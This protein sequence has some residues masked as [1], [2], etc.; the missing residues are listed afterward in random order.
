MDKIKEFLRKLGFLLFKS[1]YS[2]RILIMG[3]I[4]SFGGIAYTSW[5]NYSETA[6]VAASDSI[7]KIK[8]V[9]SVF[10]LRD[11]NLDKVEKI[12][13]VSPSYSSNK[14]ILVKYK[15]ATTVDVYKSV[16]IEEFELFNQNVIGTYIKE[17]PKT[18]LDIKFVPSYDL[19]PKLLELKG[20]PE[21]SFT[22]IDNPNVQRGGG[23]IGS[24]L[25][26]LMFMGMMLYGF[27][28][29]RN[30]TRSSFN[31]V[32]PK[33]ITD[34]LDDLVGMED[35]KS[36]LNQ[37][38]EM[39]VLQDVYQRYNVKKNF[40]VMLTGPAGV[41][42]TKIT[43][44][45]A[46]S[47][48]IP[49]I[50]ASG[51]GLETGYVGG[52]PKTLRQLVKEAEKHD[53]SIIFLDEA[54]NL[55]Q[56]R[57]GGRGE[58]WERETNNTLLSLLDGVN[59]S[60]SEIIWIIASN[61]DESKMKVDEAMS[62]RFQLKINFRLPNFEERKEIISR[63]L[64]RMD[65]NTTEHD[66]DVSKLASISSGLSP[67]LLENTLSRAS[68]IAIKEN[69]LVSNSILFRAFERVTVGL[70]DRKTTE[71]LYEHRKLIARHEAGHFIMKLHHALTQAG[72]DLSKV[73]ELIDVIKIST[74]S[75]SKYNALGFVLSKEKELKLN[76]LSEY[77]AEIT[78]LYGGMANEEIYY[79]SVGVTAGAHNDIEKVSQLLR[80]MIGEVGFYQDAK[81]NYSVLLDQKGLSTA[82][83][84][85]IER[86]SLDLYNQTMSILQLYK[87]FTDALV[88]K[89]M[90]DYVIDIDEALALY[91]SVLDQK[92]SLSKPQV[93]AS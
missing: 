83:V 77:E 42:K 24:F 1:K 3:F 65:E 36:E 66:L 61:L 45:L 33:D 84:S 55:L 15:G 79:S 62:R 5:L 92:T 74:E 85:L 60:K 41:G 26:N 59:T 57:V 8:V 28:F 73:K 21:Q 20:K 90:D 7:Y 56:D 37:L 81:I 31:I 50:Y 70:A 25:F 11:E 17:Q 35:I 6:K 51:S 86:K 88:D 18:K 22:K 43:R 14:D 39:V 80:V 67:A 40:N 16:S 30:Q 49:L 58:K 10:S 23:G 52:G 9:K 47:L 46:K 68:L 29:F 63:L 53:R 54:E 4:I 12:V 82:Q 87:W 76:T 64:S 78:Q 91:S 93:A 2:L 72:H 69:T 13:V 32:H 75:I 48:N 44:C 34:H 19:V 71:N 27:I 89:L 38:E